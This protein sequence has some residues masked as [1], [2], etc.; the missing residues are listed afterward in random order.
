MM[1]ILR[2]RVNITQTLD[3][4]DSRV[5]KTYV[6]AAIIREIVTA[7]ERGWNSSR[8][9]SEFKVDPKVVE[10][11]AHIAIPEQNADGIVRC[12]LLRANC[13]VFGHDMVL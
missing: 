9:S 13:R 6:S 7:R 3:M 5:L 11:I 4:Q 2:N 8:I 10:R 1:T 12:Y